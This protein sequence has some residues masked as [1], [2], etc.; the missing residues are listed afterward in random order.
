[1]NLMNMMKLMNVMM[2]YREDD[3]DDNGQRDEDR[4]GQNR[5]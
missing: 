5:P 1:M 2:L 4:G 3:A